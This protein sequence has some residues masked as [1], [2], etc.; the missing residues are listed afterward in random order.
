M[1][2]NG[3]KL[4]VNYTVITCPIVLLANNVLFDTIA[5]Y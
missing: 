5:N 2:I 1:G 4:M 3:A